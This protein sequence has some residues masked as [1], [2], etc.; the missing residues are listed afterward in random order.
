MLLALSAELRDFHIDGECGVLLAESECADGPI[1]RLVVLRWSLV[2]G[3]PIADREHS[4][5]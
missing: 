5:L 2:F 1:D 4:H 3:I